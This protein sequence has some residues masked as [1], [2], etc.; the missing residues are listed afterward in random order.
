MPFSAA[1]LALW[2]D[3]YFH[4]PATAFPGGAALT[5]GVKLLTGTAPDGSAAYDS[6]ITDYVIFRQSDATIT[7]PFE[8]G[9][10]KNWVQ[11][12]FSDPAAPTTPLVAKAPAK[13]SFAL[14]GVTPDYD[15]LGDVS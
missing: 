13:P 12:L 6:P 7:T 2:N 8:P 3:G 11:T 1:R 10:S 14:P 9:G 4:N 15:D 5:P